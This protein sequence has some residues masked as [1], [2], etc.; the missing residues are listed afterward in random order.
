VTPEEAIKAWRRFAE[1]TY[2]E[3]GGTR[4]NWIRQIM[5]RGYV[6]EE[7]IVQPVIFP[8]FAAEFLGFV[9]GETL[10]PELT[11]V[12]GKPDFTP[13]D[14]LTHPFVFEAKS[15]I[16]GTGLQG[17]DAQVLRYLEDGRPRIKSV[18][19]TNLVGI[20]VFALDDNGALHQKYAVDLRALL[21]ADISWHATTPNGQNLARFLDEFAYRELSH[22]E[23]IDRVRH[24]LPWRPTLEVTNPLWVSVRLDR[25]VEELRRDVEDQIAGGALTRAPVTDPDRRAIVDE[26]H[27]LEYRLGGD[28]EEVQDRA[29]ADYLRAAATAPAG[30]ALRQYEAHV[31][32]FAA[33]RM[34]L[35][36]V[37]E[38]LGLLP[39]QLNDGGFDE[40]MRRFDDVIREVVDH[41]FLTASRRYPALFDRQNNFTWFAPCEATYVE[42]IYQLANTYLGAIESDVLGDVYER[43]L[44]QIDRKQ[45]GQFYTPRD[46]IRLICDLVDVNA[47]ATASDNEQRELRVLDIATGSGGFLVEVAKQMRHRFDVARRKGAAILPQEWIERTAAGLVGVELQRFPAYLA[48]LN[49]LIQLGLVLRRTGSEIVPSLGVLCA[50]TMSLHNSVDTVDVPPTVAPDRTDLYM[51]VKRAPVTGHWFDAA[52]GN[53]PYVGEKRAAPVLQRTRARYPYWSDFIAPHLDVLY[54]F[55][56]LGVSKLRAGGRFGFITTEYWLRSDGARPLREYLGRTSKITHLVLFRNLGLFPDAPGQHSLVVIGER[57]LA[58]DAPLDA[59]P[60]TAT[61]PRVLIYRGPNVPAKD[62]EPILDRI[63]TARRGLGVD[64]FESTASPNTFGGDSWAE[65]VM[66]RTQIEKRRRLRRVAEPLEMKPDEGVIATPDKLK[67]R[68]AEQLPAATLNRLGWPDRS[69]GIFVVER[70]ELDTLGL[71]GAERRVLRSVIN[72]RDVY[73]YAVVL[74]SDAR[75]MLYLPSPTPDG[76]T[77]EQLQDQPFPRGMP[78]LEAH[79]RQFEPALR[80]KLRSGAYRAERRAWWSV[81]RPRRATMAYEQTTGWNGFAVA[82][83]W[84]VGG[85]NLI[86]GFTPAGSVPL[87]GL[88]AMVPG[89]RVSLGYLVGLFNSAIVQDICEALP[90]G[91]LRQHDFRALGLPHVLAAEQEIDDAAHAAAS[92]VETLVRDHATSWPRLGTELRTDFDLRTLPLDQWRPT[93]GS[94]QSWGPLRGLTWVESVR[95]HGAQSQQA[96][97]VEVNRSLFGPEVVAYSRSG[98]FISLTL[99]IDDEALLEALSAYFADAAGSRLPLREIPNLWAPIDERDLVAAHTTAIAALTDAANVY[100]RQRDRIDAIV[101]DFI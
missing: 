45:I 50:D 78:N 40:W 7:Q 89:E 48:E 32:C 9:V 29:L 70:D 73:P 91:E 41:S 54:W 20:R 49:L 62:R 74:P 12:E 92:A 75:Q 52:V 56:V 1:T 96:V 100:R 51:D 39:Q 6:D 28:W 77:V 86:V 57:V 84:G 59:D 17:F 98:A 36:R 44:E 23:K 63:R 11:G 14:A 94:A 85:Q 71:N 83:R 82:S 10:A 3:Y 27:E 55:L 53:P 95:A 68:L 61:K 64:S 65:V 60:I 19:L 101:N 22:E 88:N 33:T 79:M 69:A 25:V 2:F 97:D 58:P 66:S 76:L 35:V 13:A 4:R 43:L 34:L 15:T 16:A 81:H 46:V 8:L 90:P 42:V 47:L 21:V 87:S 37:W 5:R 26:L 24:A 99:R 38:D 72:T 31:A 18:A 67:A 93:V 80:A 30:L